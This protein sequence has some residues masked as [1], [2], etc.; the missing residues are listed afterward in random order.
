MLNANDKENAKYK[1][2]ETYI[3]LDIDFKSD[4]KLSIGSTLLKVAEIQIREKELRD[5]E[6]IIA[7]D[8]GS[9][10]AKVIA[11]GAFTYMAVSNYG[12]FRSG[13]TQIY[14]DVK[15]VS[16]RIIVQSRNDDSD[17]DNNIIRTEKRT[18]LTGRLKRVLDS[19]YFIQVN[20]NNLNQIEM[21]QELNSLKQDLVNIL[22][23][24]NAQ[25]KNEILNSLDE[26]IRNNLPRPDNAG[27]HHIYNLYARKPDDILLMNEL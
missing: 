10:K 20:I 11:F 21:R 17:I 24:M 4:K 25:E 19:I 27:V 5:I 16:E 12:S 1:I 23:I 2:F 9:L 13:L 8:E 3:K 7:A 14:D 22:E 26:D 18:G 6:I 15:Y